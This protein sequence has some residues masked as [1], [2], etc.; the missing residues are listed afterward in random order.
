[1][2]VARSG[3]RRSRIPHGLRRGRRLLLVGGVAGLVLGAAAFRAPPRRAVEP[4]H[5]V[6]HNSAYDSV[7]VEARL[8]AAPSCEANP[9]LGV[10]LLQRDRAWAIAFDQTI[11]WRRE[12]NPAQPTGTWTAWSSQTVAAGATVDITL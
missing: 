7:R 10:F 6:L 9:S 2:R 5:L 4:G 8:G 3:R 11:C 12:Q 1:M